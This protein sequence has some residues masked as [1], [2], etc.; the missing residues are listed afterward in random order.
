MLPKIEDI[1]EFIENR[2]KENAHKFS[3]PKFA[4]EFMIDAMRREFTVTKTKPATNKESHEKNKKAAED[5]LNKSVAVNIV[6]WSST[7]YKK[8]TDPSVCTVIEAMEILGTKNRRDVD[9]PVSAKMIK[10]AG[11]IWKHLLLDRQSVIDYKESKKGKKTPAPRDPYKPKPY[12]PKFW[13]IQLTKKPKKSTSCT[14]QWPGIDTELQVNDPAKI[15]EDDID[16]DD[17]F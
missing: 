15:M 5:Y 1:A 3:D 12:I 4:H 10:R 13:S 16:D 17:M 8:W 11:K 2:H 7:V 9:I 14:V 6:T